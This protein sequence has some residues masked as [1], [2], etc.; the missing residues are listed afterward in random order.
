[1]QWQISSFKFEEFYWFS[2]TF[3]GKFDKH[4]PELQI[5]QEASENMIILK[6]I[7]KPYICGIFT[8]TVKFLS[9]IFILLILNQ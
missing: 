1:M 5:Y 6:T 3:S 9:F 7:P 4:S 2:L 8:P